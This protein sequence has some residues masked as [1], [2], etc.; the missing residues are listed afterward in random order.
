MPDYVA[1]FVN[2]QIRRDDILIAIGGGI[3][4]SKECSG[5]G[6]ASGNKNCFCGFDYCTGSEVCNDGECLEPAGPP[7]PPPTTL[8]T[9]Y[10]SNG[11]CSMNASNLPVCDCSGTGYSGERCNIPPAPDDP[12]DNQ[13][14]TCEN[15]FR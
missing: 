10:C 11:V 5:S 9:N 6:N 1:H 12:C 14:F 13:N 15:G 2:R 3:V 7:P 4:Y 8:C